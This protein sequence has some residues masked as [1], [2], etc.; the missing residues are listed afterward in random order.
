MAIRHLSLRLESDTFDRLETE[1]QRSG[2][3][4]SQ[5]AKTLLEE[6]LRM[7]THAG[8]V[9]RSGPAVRRPGPADGP[10]VWAV[11][12]VFKGVDARGE[13][14]LRRTA[15]LTGFTREQVRIAMRY[16]AEYPDEIDDWIR[17]VDEEAAQVE[18]AWQREH[19]RLQR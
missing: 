3:S 8:M 16:Y 15:D 13:E 4:R 2:Q 9:F 10:D 18:A 7:E 14:A 19:N 11:V 1:S 5:L 17:R 6:G 12:R